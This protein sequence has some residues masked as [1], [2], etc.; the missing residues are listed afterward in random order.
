M[1]RDLVEQALRDGTLNAADHEQMLVR[2]DVVAARA[3]IPA[4]A[5][6]RT[7]R[8]YVGEDGIE[9]AWA[10]RVIRARTAPPRGLA[11]VGAW[12]DVPRRMEA[13]AGAFVRNFVDARVF[14]LGRALE[15]R[16]ESLVLFVPNFYAAGKPPAWQVGQ[17]LDF[18]SERAAAGRATVVYAQ[19]LEGVEA[20]LGRPTRDL[21]ERF[22]QL[23]RRR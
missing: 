1:S 14:P 3:G 17:I 10:A 19:S 4:E 23:V 22:E 16:P 5:I 21:V 20:D 12:P 2:L 9:R 15:E 8:A 18:L 13:L 7:F 6:C 11:Y